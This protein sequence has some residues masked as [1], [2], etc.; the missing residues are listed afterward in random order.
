VALVEEAT[1]ELLTLAAA[2]AELIKQT[3][4]VVL[5]ALDS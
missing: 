1:Q 2:V 5:V 3:L 4:L